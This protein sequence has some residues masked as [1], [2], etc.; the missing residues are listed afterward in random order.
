MHAAHKLEGG[1]EGGREGEREGDGQVHARCSQAAE[2][3]VSGGSGCQSTLLAQNNAN[4]WRRYVYLCNVYVIINTSLFII[5][6]Y[7]EHAVYTKDNLYA[8]WILIFTVGLFL[9]AVQIHLYSSSKAG[10]KLS[11]S[12]EVQVA[13][14]YGDQTGSVDGMMVARIPAQQQQ[15]NR[16]V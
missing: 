10:T 13:A 3:T 14:I 7:R 6:L 11:S 8:P 12:L 9:T 5:K 1:R 16:E 2:E 15:G 4:A